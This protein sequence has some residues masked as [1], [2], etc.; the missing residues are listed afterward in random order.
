[1]G[2]LGAGLLPGTLLVS[3]EK[4]NLLPESDDPAKNEFIPRHQYNGPYSGEYL[5]RIA[6]PIGGLGAGMFCLEGTGAISHMSV[7]NKPEIF[8]EPGWFAAICIKGQKNNS[9]I[10]GF[11]RRRVV[12]SSLDVSKEYVSAIA[13]AKCFEL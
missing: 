2:G 7:R 13:G 11:L 9:S 3:T 4:Q 5:N 10:L 1:M 12:D 6:F 8:N